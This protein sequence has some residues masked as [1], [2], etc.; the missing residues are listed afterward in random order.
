MLFRTKDAPS[1][2]SSGVPCHFDEQRA[3]L[4]PYDLSAE[5]SSHLSTFRVDVIEDKFFGIEVFCGFINAK[6]D[7]RRTYTSASQESD[8]TRHSDP[9]EWLEVPLCLGAH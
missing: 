1:I 5:A 9:Q 4:A 6:S 7:K 2:A 8:F 3:A